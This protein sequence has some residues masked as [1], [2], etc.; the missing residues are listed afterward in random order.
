MK[1]KTLVAALL[2]A[3]TALGDEV[4]AVAG[5]DGHPDHLRQLRGDGIPRISVRFKLKVK[6]QLEF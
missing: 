4:T 1:V 3:L 2:A 6:H 5:S